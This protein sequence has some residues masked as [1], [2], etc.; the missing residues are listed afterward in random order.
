MKKILL[1]LFSSLLF[2]SCADQDDNLV[3]IT[4]PTSDDFY[5][6]F[7]TEM[8]N[9]TQNFQM[10]AEDGITTFTSTQG[11]KLTIDGNCL[12]LNGQP[13]TGTVDIEFV[14]IF[15]RGNMLV[16]N[17]TTMGLHNGQKHL[18][19]S[20]GEFYINATQNG[21]QLTLTCSYEINVPAAITGT[22]DNDMLPFTGT[23]DTMGNVTW[24][25]WTGGEWWV[26][27]VQGNPDSYN[28][29]ISNFGW[30]NCDRFANTLGPHT[31]LSAFVPEGYGN[32]NSLV[33]LALSGEPNTLGTIFGNFPI[34][35]QC[36]LIFVSENNGQYSYSIL[37]DQTLVENHVVEFHANEMQ[38]A[39][40]EQLA[41]IINALP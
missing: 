33:L 11:V 15:D 32:G 8:E 35:L 20:G 7:E 2:F 27:S 25:Q 34:G 21:Q 28:A 14:E 3:Q 4:G 6:L 13:V 29:F 16:T 36:H 31:T 23:L 40:A 1:A 30:F 12:Q 5:A 10:N 38:T 39:T 19:I 9:Q 17:K 18:L 24:E 26:G 41:G 37:Q 22:T